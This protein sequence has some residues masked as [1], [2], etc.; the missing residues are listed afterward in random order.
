MAQFFDQ[1]RYKCALAAMQ[2]VQ[3]IPG[4]IPIMH[5]GP[6]CGYKLNDNTGVSGK[7]SI[8]IFPCTSVSEKEVVFGG[9]GKLRDTIENAIRIIDADLFIV[10]TGCT[11]EIIGDD[12][13]A[14][15][16][17][18]SGAE[19]KVIHANTPG[20]KG[21]NYN[22]HDWIMDAIFEQYLPE[23][24]KPRVQKGLVN[25]FAGPPIHDP[26]WY[27][28]LRQLEALVAEIG[29]TPNTVFGHDRGLKNIDKIP[30]AEFN[31]LVSPWLGY[32]GVK[33]LEKKYGTPFLQFPYLP[34]GATE[35]SRFLRRVAE[36][37]GSGKELAERV[38]E[39]HEAEFFYF[40]ERYA[41][42]FLE[43]RIMSKRFVTVTEAQYAIGLT[44]FLTHDLG[45]FPTTQYITDNP[46]NEFRQKILDEFKTLNYGVEA[47][48]EFFTNGVDVH[49]KI[50]Q[51]DFAGYPLILGS[52]HEKALAEQ[53]YGIYLNISYPVLT[54]IVINTGIA[55]YDGGLKFLEQIYTVA[56]GRLLL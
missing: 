43:M 36:F 30:N 27:G 33:I 48:T 56:A 38:I 55:G 54:Q 50:K 49:N 52:S 20:F 13:A 17:E 16:E 5:A 14:V 25:I 2:T 42:L 28:N 44:K 22:G 45:M 26:Y 12:I 1:P 23:I 7:F 4:A 19:K 51:T 31:L 29:L 9:E 8:N 47:P 10:I 24:E 18:F 37:S 21:S 11:S 32:S 53:T 35:T 15:V 46:P 6:G 39:K 3:S 41:D 40:I 34:I